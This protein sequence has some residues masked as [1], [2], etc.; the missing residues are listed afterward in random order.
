MKSVFKAR[1]LIFGQYNH[2][3]LLR[4]YPT[5]SVAA[6][7]RILKINEYG[8]LLLL[9]VLLLYNKIHSQ[10][11]SEPQI[12][13]AYIYK[14][15]ENIKWQNE[16]QFEAF[17]IKL[18][19]DNADII[20][21]FRK[22][23]STK[24]I[25]G[26]PVKLLI[27]GPSDDIDKAQIIYISKNKHHL[28]KDIYERI[29]KNILLIS[30]EYPDKRFIMLNFYK[31]DDDKIR[32]EINRENII[33][34]GLT[35]L[36]DM[37]LLGGTKI[38]VIKLYEESQQKLHHLQGQINYY[39]YILDSLKSFVNLSNVKIEKQKA[40]MQRQ[41]NIIRQQMNEIKSDKA[42]LTNMR[43]SLNHYSQMLQH[44]YQEVEKNNKYLR[45]KN[46]QIDSIN[47]EI[48]KKN[49]ILAKKEKIIGRQKDVLVLL[50]IIISLS[51]I[52]LFFIIYVYI[53]NR[54]KSIKLAKQQ[55]EIQRIN[56]EL[57]KYNAELEA[58]LKEIKHMQQKLVKSEK[59]ASLGILSAGIA[60]EI[61]NPINFV[62]AGINSLIQD[63][64]D[65]EPVIKAIHALHADSDNLVEQISK[66]DRLKKKYDFEEAI[67][68]IPQII[69]DIKLGADRT[70]EI[71][72]GLRQFSRTD[73]GNFHNYSIHEAI[74]TALLLLK[75]KY[76]NR[77]R[78]IKNFDKKIPILKGHLGEMIQ[79]FLNLFSN[80]IDAISDSGEIRIN[81][82]LKNNQVVIS[83]RDSGHGIKK[84]I[85][86][87][88]FDPFFTTKEVGQGT[89]LG[90]AI[91]YGIVKEHK[92]DIQVM[93][94]PQNGSEFIITLP[95]S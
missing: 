81:T 22:L 36:P 88:I 63:F 72:K 33:L 62:Y 75:N 46:A 40:I 76:K 51:V 5:Q 91:C 32:F 44:L 10:E 65:I 1:I 85:I 11:L 9:T 69:A 26:L 45:L 84:E 28:Y 93:S 8:L 49:N 58:S 74:D 34:H 24:R 56:S 53:V 30:D 87:K 19:T 80:A 29:N 25:K 39:K 77:I 57:Q 94:E 4:L 92:G 95:V 3:L 7:I 42:L 67:Q 55:E 6:V 61:N 71:I 17:H 47:S 79:V 68:S 43:D 50:F 16:K 35:L 66:I 64:K 13:V 54:K 38:D 73:K 23:S 70:A 86:E 27:N 12:K 83:V 20:D 21:E 37:V 60:H 78:I 14:F 90:L 18:F 41:S 31:T 59:M 89:G 48:E 2:N 52:F 82:K 15:A